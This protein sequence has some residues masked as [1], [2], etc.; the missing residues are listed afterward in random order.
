[1]DIQ[2]TKI[3]LVKHLLKVKKE[4]VLN[5]IKEILLSDENE[6]VVAY[7][8]DGNSLTLSQYQNELK[9][10]EKEIERGEYLTSDELDKEI[11]TWSK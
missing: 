3:E 2:A 6:E 1:M 10:A 9:E 8:I 11:A 4:S 5:K 7:T